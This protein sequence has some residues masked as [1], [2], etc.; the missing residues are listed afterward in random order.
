MNRR[1]STLP[2]T[3]ETH[4]AIGAPVIDL[5]KTVRIEKD[6]NRIG[7]IEAPAR[8]AGLAFPVVPLEFHARP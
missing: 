8:K 2:S 4:L 5:D 6:P 1:R 3:L 7:E